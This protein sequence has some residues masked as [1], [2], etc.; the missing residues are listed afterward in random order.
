M[1]GLCFCYD[2]FQTVWTV[3]RMSP[4]FLWLCIVCAW[5]T[6]FPAVTTS[7]FLPVSYDVPWCVGLSCAMCAQWPCWWCLEFCLPFAQWRHWNM[8]L[9]HIWTFVIISLWLSFWDVTFCQIRP[10]HSIAITRTS[11]GTDKYSYVNHIS[12]PNKL[13]LPNDSTFPGQLWRFTRRTI[14]S[15]ENQSTGRGLQEVIC[16]I[17]CASQNH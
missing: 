12:A 13:E 4:V 6:Q 8:S 17:C 15:S 16:S 2:K 7:I 3:E 14:C 9:S 11:E 10:M 1:S 5:N